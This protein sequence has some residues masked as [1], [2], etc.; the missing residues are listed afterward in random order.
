M[1]NKG[2]NWLAF[3]CLEVQQPIGIFYLVVMKSKDLVKLSYSDV[4]RI[5]GERRQVET[6][7]G[8]ERPLDRKKR[9]PQIKQY[10]NTIDASFPTSIILAVESADTK[11]MKELGTL[12]LRDS[13]SVAKV[14]DGQHRIAGLEDYAK[15][16]FE[17]V[18][19]I[20]V[21]MDIENQAMIFATINLEQT[22]VNKSLVY[23]LFDYAQQ[24]SPQK[25]A[26]NIVRL[27]D[28]E[29][30]SPFRGKIKI[31]GVAGD[32]GETLSQAL[33]VDSLLPMIS[34]DPMADRDL[35]KRGKRPAR[36]TPAEEQTYIFRNMFL[37]ERDAEIAR[38]LWNYFAAVEKKWANIGGRPRRAMF[39]IGRLDFTD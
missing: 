10:V 28:S 34:Q 5:E 15:D 2:D 21:D 25:T 37:D 36:A 6:Y 29:G 4:R 14:L 11:Y 18:V 23:D 16:D 31:L 26:H 22:K 3:K 32:P 1:D 7:L 33:F 12:F 9:V 17:L 13:P 39:S 38:V 20:F 30:D 27:L 24:R 8:I 35:I 19:T